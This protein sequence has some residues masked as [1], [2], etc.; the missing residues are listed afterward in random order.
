MLLAK[1]FVDNRFEENYVSDGKTLNL[2]LAVAKLRL[3]V[4]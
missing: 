2:K 3:L 1:L 4:N